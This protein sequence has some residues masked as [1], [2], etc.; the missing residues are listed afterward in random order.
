VSRLTG[1]AAA[2]EAVLLRDAVALAEDDDMVDSDWP[3]RYR[4]LLARCRTL[5]SA[6]VAAYM[7]PVRVA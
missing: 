6:I 7:R 4:D 2:E 1:G 3:A 5:H